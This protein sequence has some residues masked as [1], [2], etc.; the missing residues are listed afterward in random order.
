MTRW[1]VKWNEEVEI[2]MQGELPAVF[3]TSFNLHFIEAGGDLLTL[4]SLGRAFVFIHSVVGV[5]M[6]ERTTRGRD[7]KKKILLAL[8]VSQVRP[9]C[10]QEAAMACWVIRM[11]VGR[12]RTYQTSGYC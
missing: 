11:K 7:E 6:A 4:R 2:T 5:W 9:G 12:C 10:L 3:S 1:T 8:K